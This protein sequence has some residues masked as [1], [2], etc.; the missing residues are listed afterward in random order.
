MIYVVHANCKCELNKYMR[1]NRCARRQNYRATFQFSSEKIRWLEIIAPCIVRENRSE[2]ACMRDFSSGSQFRSIAAVVRVHA[3]TMTSGP[4]PTR[5]SFSLSRLP[6][7][8]VATFHDCAARNN[9][10]SDTRSGENSRALGFGPGVVTPRSRAVN[11][12]VN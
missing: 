8:N 9:T 3:S 6:R 11:I 5:R 10:V 12:D 2:H 1:G 7:Y 4:L